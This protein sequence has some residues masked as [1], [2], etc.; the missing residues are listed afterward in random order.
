MPARIRILLAI[1]DLRGGGAERE[2]QLLARHLSRERF[3][4]H[5][6]FWREVFD[7]PPP[8]DL[9]IHWVRKT[10]PWHAPT[11][12]LGLR[13]LLD[14]LR[15]A[16]VFSQLHYV[17]LLVGTALAMAR[18]RPRWAWRQVNDPRRELRGP[19]ASWARLAL[20]RADR[21]LGCSDGVS[22]ALVEHLRLDPARVATL[23]NLVD[24]ARVEALS[25]EPLPI[26]RRPEVFA[27]AHAGRLS[28]QKNQAL[29]LQAVSRLR[30]RPA[31]LWL[32]G[33]GPEEGRLRRLAARLG[34]AGRVRWLGFQANPYP[35]FRAADC[36]ALSSHHEGL[37]NAVIESMALGTP[38]VSTRCPYGPEELIED[39]VSGRLVPPGDAAALA[40]A[41]SELAADPALARRLGRAA[42][43]RTA[44]DFDTAR[45]CRA[46]ESLF[47]E[48]A[49]SG[50]ARDT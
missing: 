38:V 36:F 42:R 22:R 4:A 24:L 49:G 15:P 31:E 25:R 8:P 28:R 47:E 3:E 18:H 50:P 35:F 43:E 17:N 48:L 2:F 32:L 11:A 23:R 10:R 12:V 6:C 39:G 41:L 1:S 46:Y 30:G 5:L 40:G 14:E 26:E 20:R 34:L 13:R 19:F 29:L 21:A 16:V 9:P 37:P 27:I 33:A 44:A 7:Y 45:S